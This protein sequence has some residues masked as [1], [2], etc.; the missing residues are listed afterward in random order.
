MRDLIDFFYEVLLPVG[1][2]GLCVLAIILGLSEAGQRYSCNNY[3]RVTGRETKW[4][5]LDE[6]YVK[7]AGGWER[8]DE[9][10]Y[11]AATNE[12]KGSD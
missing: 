12:R 7:A 8:W 2:V 5:F 4:I 1:L 6:C 3:E 11:R 9:Y 10:K